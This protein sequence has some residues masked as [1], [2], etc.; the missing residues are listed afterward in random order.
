MQVDRSHRPSPPPPPQLDDGEEGNETNFSLKYVRNRGNL[1]T[2][3][4]QQEMKGSRKNR[5]ER[6]KEKVFSMI[7][8]FILAG[9]MALPLSVC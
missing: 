8:P 2:S 7:K 6:K 9:K 5:M 4:Q 3:N 1:R